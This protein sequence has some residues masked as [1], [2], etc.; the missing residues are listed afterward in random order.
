MKKNREGPRRY[1]LTV[2][3]SSA[4]EREKVLAQKPP[5]AKQSTWLRDVIKKTLKIK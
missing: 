4:E 1:L 2:Y 5:L 3:F